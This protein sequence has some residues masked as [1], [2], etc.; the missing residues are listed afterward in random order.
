MIDTLT[1]MLSSAAD[2]YL[3]ARERIKVSAFFEVVGGAFISLSA[4]TVAILTRDLGKI[5]MVYAIARGIQFVSMVA[6]IHFRLHGFRAR[7]YLFDIG[8]QLKYGAILGVGGSI[9][10][11]LMRVHNI[12]V[13]SH[14]GREV[15]AVYSAGCTEIPV[16]QF[17]S[18][19]LATVAMTRFA[20]LVR[21]ENWDEVKRLWREIMT[22]MYGVTIPIILVFLLVAK[23]L[24]LILFTHKYADATDIFMINTLAKLN[25]IW[26]ATLI[27]R[28]M[29]RND[30]TLYLNIATL[31]LAIPSMILMSRTF[32]MTGVII[33]H[34]TLL[35][36][37]K[38][39]AV[40]LL[41]RV[42]GLKLCYFVSL[43]TVFRFYSESYTKMKTQIR[44]RLQF[45]RNS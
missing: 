24:V 44:S 3:L 21:D 39:V 31:V 28:A 14:Y 33:T 17:F 20:V 19:G 36:V 18:Q 30:I 29:K 23:P 37:N 12:I 11:L 5:F 32:G 38:V 15:F 35:V 25:F 7:K 45:A 2:C 42:S 22:S 40:Y 27:I 26:N 34:S 13:S 1:I 43:P 16:L 6:Y 9:G 8:V 4:L 41:N 10:A